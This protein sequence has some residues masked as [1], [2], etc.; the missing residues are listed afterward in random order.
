[1]YL[2]TKSGITIASGRLPKDAEYKLVGD[3]NTPLCKFGIAA[4]ETRDETGEKHTTWCNCVAWRD[5]AEA[6]S[7][8]RK[9][10]TVLVTGMTASRTYEGANGEPRTIEECT[11]NFVSV[12]PK[13]ADSGLD[14]LSR[15]PNVRDDKGIDVAF[16]DLGSDDGDLPF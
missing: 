7:R 3:K 4:N 9:G 11:V 6:A 16:D 13:C 15:F 2:K 12:M 1:M 5:V 14:S 10:D 8:L